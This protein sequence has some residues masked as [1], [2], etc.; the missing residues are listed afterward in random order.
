MAEIV[1]AIIGIA[2]C[3]LCFVLGII[4]ERKRR[5]REILK[6]IVKRMEQMKEGE[7]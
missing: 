2:A 1:A 3:E 6:Y 5:S 7:K 4:Y